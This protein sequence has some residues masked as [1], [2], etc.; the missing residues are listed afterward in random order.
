MKALDPTKQLVDRVFDHES[1][2]G[3]VICLTAARWAVLLRMANP[4]AAVTAEP[5][6]ARDSS[7]DSGHSFF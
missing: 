5:P 1:F 7:M 4:S 3:G 2:F 6:C